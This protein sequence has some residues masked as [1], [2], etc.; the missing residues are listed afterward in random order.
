[1]MVL[2]FFRPFQTILE[3][4][5]LHNYYVEA[6]TTGENEATTEGSPDCL[7]ESSVGGTRVEF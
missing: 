5:S 3:I 2:F 7:K 1:M 4:S 6:S